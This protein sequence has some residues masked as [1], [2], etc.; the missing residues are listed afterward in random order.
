M[1]VSGQKNLLAFVSVTVGAVPAPE[2]I[3][4]SNLE[5]GAWDAV[6]LQGEAL[7]P[8]HTQAGG[9]GETLF[10]GGVQALDI[11]VNHSVVHHPARAGNWQWCKLHRQVTEVL[12]GSVPGQAGG[13][14]MSRTQRMPEEVKAEPQLHCKTPLAEQFPVLGSDLDLLGLVCV[15]GR[16]VCP[17]ESSRQGG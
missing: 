11:G 3:R 8:Q 12:P 14:E 7:L 2:R 4:G 9:R 13:E 16:S 17:L 6:W 10:S 1:S 5:R 15:R